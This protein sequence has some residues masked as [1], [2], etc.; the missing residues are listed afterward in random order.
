VASPGTGGG[1]PSAL[2]GGGPRG[3]AP[4]G[5]SSGVTRGQ[6]GTPPTTLPETGK[7][8]VRV[9]GAGL[10]LLGGGVL[11]LALSAAPSRRRV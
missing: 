3:A 2:G 4:T 1:S 9:A 10:M 8:I 5:A 6:A 11:L 7:P